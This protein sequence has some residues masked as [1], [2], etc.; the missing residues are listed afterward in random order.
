MDWDQIGSVVAAC[1]RDLDAAAASGGRPLPTG[2]V[3]VER[4]EERGIVTVH[5]HGPIKT[6][7]DLE[8]LAAAV[9]QRTPCA[10]AAGFVT[11]MPRAVWAEMS[12]ESYVPRNSPMDFVGVIHVE[13]LTKGSKT[14]IASMENM[15]ADA[16]GWKLH[17]E[18]AYTTA[19]SCIDSRRYGGIT[20]Q[21]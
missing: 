4:G 2:L 3:F 21:A 12:G 18:G 6:K 1:Q 15:N 13:H 17:R 16:E 9:R 5:R 8:S 11:V 20:G 14:W 19:P 10:A 7:E